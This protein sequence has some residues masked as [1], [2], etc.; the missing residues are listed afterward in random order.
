[1]TTSVGVFVGEPSSIDPAHG[2][3]HDGAL[4]LRFLADPLVDFTPDAGE[5]R[6]AAAESWGVAPDG[7]SV[8]FRL[9]DGV[10]FHHGRPVA[11][12]DYV[13]S[14]ARVVRPETGSELGYVFD[15]VEGYEDVSA[16]R[17]ATLSGTIARDARTLEVRLERP[18]HEIPRLFGHRVTSAVP[19]E[20]VEAD[21]DAFARRPVST[22]PYRMAAD[23]DF[24]RLVRLERFPEYY[25]AN[26]AF[27]DGGRGHLDALEFR[28]Y[29]DVADAFDD[30]H[31]GLVDVTKVPPPRVQDAFGAGDS[32]RRTPCALMQYVGFPVDVAPFDDPVVRRAVAMCIDRRRIIDESFAGTRPLANRI[33]PPTIVGAEAAADDFA[34]VEHDPERARRMVA[35]RGLDGSLALDFRYN[36]GLGHDEWVE[37]VVADV[38]SALGWRITIVPMRWPE[39]MKWLPHADSPFR[40]TWG[41]DYPSA[42]NFLFP[43]LHSASIGMDNFTRYADARVDELLEAARATADASERA[44]LYFEAERRACEQLPLLPLWFGVQYHLVALDRFDVDG[45]PVDVFGEPTL[46]LYRARAARR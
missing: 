22:G 21:P 14:W 31:R 29:E 37:A 36:A 17:A 18:F 19:R 40:M 10:R 20:L 15:V 33:L 11:A 1:M 6:P 42:D 32:F 27:S 44:R 30:W 7:R 13:Y 8:V 39:F 5:P 3:E 2:F 12:E 4:V 25:G 28:V 45:P 24:R 34:R 23:A 43:L 26:A 9:R 35:E 16:G 38:E 41:M 46:R